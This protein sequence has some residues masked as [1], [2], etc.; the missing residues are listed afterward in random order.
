MQLTI[1]FQCS[2]IICL[3]GV[4][5]DPDISSEVVMLYTYRHDHLKYARVKCV[6]RFLKLPDMWGMKTY[7]KP[8]LRNHFLHFTMG[9]IW[10]A[11]VVAGCRLI[12]EPV[13]PWRSVP[14]SG[15]GR[16]SSCASADAYN[17]WRSASC[18]SCGGRC[19]DSQD[20]CPGEN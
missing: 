2:S 1:N 15:E 11:S 17:P 7:Y 8:R 12:Y 10:Q 4:F 16:H 5:P 3:W 19:C 13:W 6:D 18:C 14:K 20:H 9:R